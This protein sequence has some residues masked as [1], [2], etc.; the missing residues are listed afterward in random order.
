[1]KKN[2][3]FHENNSWFMLQRYCFNGCLASISYVVM[4]VFVLF[5]VGVD[6][7]WV[8]KRVKEKLS[9][10]WGGMVWELWFESTPL[11]IYF[12]SVLY[13]RGMINICNDIKYFFYHTNLYRWLPLVIDVGKPL[14]L[15]VH[16]KLVLLPF[17]SISCTG[18]FLVAFPS[19][20]A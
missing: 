9:D 14:P 20:P 13:R 11:L 6:L 1:M 5:C 7:G 19:N 3:F 8:G 17:L 18:K 16:V 2:I 15:K 10:Q 12:P 4:S